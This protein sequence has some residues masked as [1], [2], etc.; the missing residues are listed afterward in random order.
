MRLLSISE[1]IDVVIRSALRAFSCSVMLIAGPL[2]AQDV[3][4][5]PERPP[6]LE[7]TRS[8]GEVLI[9]GRLDEADWQNALPVSGFKQEE[10]NQGYAP[11]YDTEV[12]VL[13]DA[14]NLYVSA[15]CYDQEGP[16][17]IRVQDLRRD[18]DFFENDVFGVSLDPFKDGRNAIIFQ[19][20]PYGVL[21]DLQ[22]TDGTIFNIDWDATYEARTSIEADRWVVEIAIPWKVL[23]YAPDQNTWGINFVRGIR[24]L[25]EFSGWSLWP[26]VY[27]PYRMDYAGTLN[28]IEP[29]PP[30]TNLRIQPYLVMRD[31]RVGESENLFDAVTPEIGGDVKWAMTPSTVLDLTV[32]TDFA[33]AD[34]DRQVVNLSRFS[35]FFPEKRAFFLENASL[36]RMGSSTAAL[37]FFSRRIGLDDFGQPIPIDAGARLISR[38]GS[39][40]IGALFVRQ[41]SNTTS[42]VSHFGVGRY[43]RNLGN[44]NRIGALA[45]LRQDEGFDGQPAEVNTVGAVDGLFRFTQTLTLQG[46]VSGSW[47]RE[48]EGDG[49]ASYLWLGNDSNRGYLGHIQAF[50]SENYNPGV[51]F[52]ARRDLIVTSPAGSLDLRP[53]WKPAFIRSFN[54]G[55]VTYVYHRLSD[56]AFQEA[57]LSIAPV[58][59]EFVNGAEINLRMQPNWQTLRVQDV[60]FFRPLGV[61]LEAGD[62][63]YIR[64]NA[65]I[66]SDLSRR[67]SGFAEVTTGPYFDGQLTTMTVSVR[68]APSPHMSLNLDYELNRATGLGIDD[69]NVDSHLFGPE[70]RL[71]LNPRFQLN[72]FYQYNTLIERARWNVR[73]SYEFSPLSYVFLVF[74]DN[75]YFVNDTLR[76]S[77][78]AFFAT[79]QQAIFKVSYLRQL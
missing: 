75:R 22:V 14:K 45:T 6:V 48:R 66:Q 3:F 50:I 10:P 65:E 79:Q 71:A 78:P 39:R 47:T 25:G 33:Q 38:T 42:P 13:F 44:S 53:S 60:E 15:V 56:G 58:S 55:F 36:F 76:R 31:E 2:C 62:H 17:G 52:V 64:Y 51:G 61:E 16:E 24:R 73:L 41:R 23:R 67:Y 57:W 69:E 18:F 72:A 1:L 54:P 40:N 26:R 77:D 59:I 27:T 63:S 29:P 35:V 8:T 7:A 21:R 37:P 34:A 46:M 12:R 19:V 74:N 32:N 30:S 11:S 9:D 68:L 43:S 49:F 70:L 20:N 5:P 4:P 28:N